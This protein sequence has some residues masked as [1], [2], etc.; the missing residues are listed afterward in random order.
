MELYCVYIAWIQYK[1]VILMLRILF[2]T[3]SK[4]NI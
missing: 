4:L 3:D 2:P 1:Y